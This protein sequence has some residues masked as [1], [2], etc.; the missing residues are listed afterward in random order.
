MTT[1]PIDDSL[2]KEAADR[3]I[4]EHRKLVGDAF[5][6]LEKKIKRDKSLNFYKTAYSPD[7]TRPF[8]ETY[9][10]GT[11]KRS[12]SILMSLE[13]GHISEEEQEMRE[14][15]GNTV[16]PVCHY[17]DHQS[18]GSFSVPTMY[19]AV[20]MRCI[21]QMYQRIHDKDAQGGTVRAGDVSEQLAGAV[22]YADMWT[23]ALTGCSGREEKI[24]ERL[25]L[26]VPAKDGLFLCNVESGRFTFGAF[27]P[28]RSLSPAQK[29]AK[30]KLELLMSPFLNSMIQFKHIPGTPGVGN[31]N[32][33]FHFRPV[34]FLTTML[35][36]F[37]HQNFRPEDYRELYGC[38]GVGDGK[39]T[40]QTIADAM[41]EET[42]FTYFP[43]GAPEMKDMEDL[44]AAYVA[45]GEREFLRV[46]GAS[47][48][49]I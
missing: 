10:G 9:V 40:F 14:P 28:D 1:T 31:P 25:S 17:T 36:R 48:P 13:S 23:V 22:I 4:R 24:L 42:P 18:M 21:L 6:I 12:F 34:R 39:F 32:K 45:M 3:F 26:P 7:V 27:V 38:D 11:N 37:V 30:G 29:E 35:G 33:N 47:L 20:S 15:G 16:L 19:V 5:D 46:K 2:E 43:K 41:K 44:S 49:L 8:V